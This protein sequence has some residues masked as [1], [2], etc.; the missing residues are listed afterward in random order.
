M[1]SKKHYHIYERIG[2]YK[3][4]NTQYRCIDPDCTHWNYKDML[5]GKRAMCECGTTY[6]L[7]WDQLRLRRPRCAKCSTGKRH[8]EYMKKQKGTNIIKDIMGGVL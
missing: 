5:R 8:E 7:T 3:K 2:S 1:P 4:P 6:L